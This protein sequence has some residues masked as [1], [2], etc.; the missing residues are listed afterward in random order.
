MQIIYAA[1]FLLAAA[2]CFCTCAAIRSTRKNALILPVGI[3]LFGPGSLISFGIFALIA[4]GLGHKGSANWWYLAPY[5]IG[6]LAIAV[7]CSI[8]WRNIVASLPLSL[9]K[10]S[11]IAATFASILAF[12]PFGS[13][14][15]SHFIALDREHLGWMILP[16]SLW[17]LTSSFISWKLIK[18]SEQF[19]PIAWWPAFLKRHTKDTI[20]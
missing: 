1:P 5:I 16:G 3:L 2:I 15:V 9:V 11:L 13:W 19:Q 6:G 8:I 10:V 14:C 18:I 12:L 7:C 4:Y 20:L 17:L